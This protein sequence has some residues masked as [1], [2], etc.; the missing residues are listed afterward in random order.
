MWFFIVCFYTGKSGSNTTLLERFFETDQYW[1]TIG[2][3]GFP[4][5][6]ILLFIVP[7]IMLRKTGV[8]KVSY[9][10]IELSDKGR[11]LVYHISSISEMTFTKDVPFKGDSRSRSQRAGRLQFTYGKE[12]C[13]FEFNPKTEN[14]YKDLIP[15]TQYWKENIN[16]FKVKYK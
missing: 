8:L 6:F 2:Y 4:I 3:I 1:R 5:T 9:D 14:D 10:K 11:N 12:K 13:D 15:A 16:G 7:K